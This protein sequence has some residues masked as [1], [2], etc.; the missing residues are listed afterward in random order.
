A[1]TTKVAA[2]ANAANAASEFAAADDF[3]ATAADTAANAAIALFNESTTKAYVTDDNWDT[4]DAD[5]AASADA[6]ARA[7]RV[8]IWRSISAD[9]TRI[10]RGVTPDKLAGE[11]LWMGKTP[12]RFHENWEQ[13]KLNLIGLNPDWLSWTY[14]YEARRDG[15]LTYRNS[16]EQ[17][18]QIEIARAIIKD[19]IWD[20]GP[21]A[22]FAEIRRLENEILGEREL[23]E[24]GDDSD[25]ELAQGPGPYRYIWRGGKIEASPATDVPFDI[26]LAEEFLQALR[27]KLSE[28]QSVLT[29]NHADPPVL[30]AIGRLEPLLESSAADISIGLIYMRAVSIEAFAQAYA[31]SSGEREN[32]IRAALSDVSESLSMLT[33]CYPIIQ[34]LE[35]NRLAIELQSADAV[36]VESSLREIED[37][38]TA[39]EIA[40]ESVVVAL[41]TGREDVDM[42]SEKAEQTSVHSVRAT[43]IEERGKLVAQ[44][45]LNFKNLI[46]EVLKTAGSQVSG[47]V[48][49]SWSAARRGIPKG[50]E[51]GSK[52][53]AKAGVK[54]CAVYLAFKLL[55]PLVGL[56]ALV[57]LFQPFAKRAEKIAEEAENKKAE[58]S[59]G[60][61]DENHSDDANGEESIEI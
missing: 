32:N 19:A 58:S 29:G 18:E 50:I 21:A 35:A 45:V 11:P 37:V 7:A 20:E 24:D 43:Y 60:E 55:G 54:G 26:D 8:A 41:A 30:A 15:R 22:V 2:T 23:G 28:T 27:E 4:T 9:A 33:A 10:Q 39:S 31:D 48:G 46:G 59:G 38:A 14:W 3:A 44:R 52:D 16:P 12:D 17:N 1:T 34:T 51:E 53:V 40:G 47:L 36:A 49:D 25:G 61:F 13:L 57:V 56:S 6:A 5:S 42:L